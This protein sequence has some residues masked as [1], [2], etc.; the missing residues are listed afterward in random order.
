LSA[1]D[2][3]NESSA[4]KPVVFASAAAALFIGAY[5]LIPH[6]SPYGSTAIRLELAMYSLVHVVALAAAARVALRALSFERTFW[7]LLAAAAALVIV[8]DLPWTIAV[9]S[10]NPPPPT[11]TFTS[12]LLALVPAAVFY[13]LIVSMTQVRSHAWPVR[14]R[15][16]LSGAIALVIVF[17]A[18]FVLVTRPLM[19]SWGLTDTPVLLRGTLH[20]VIGIGIL[21]GVAAMLAGFKASAWK[22]WEKLLLAGFAVYGA[23]LAMTPYYY[24]HTSFTSAFAAQFHEAALMSGPA[25]VALAALSRLLAGGE[26]VPLRRTVPFGPARAWR[27][28]AVAWIALVAIAVFVVWA[29]GAESGSV[30]Q[31]LALASA[32]VL[33]GLLAAFLAAAAYEAAALITALT[34]DRVSGVHTID[35]LNEQLSGEVDVARRCGE[36]LAVLVIYVDGFHRYVGVHGTESAE[37]L[38]REVA[39]VISRTVGGAEKTA[40]IEDN[41]FACVVP[42][43]ARAQAEQLAEKVRVAVRSETPLTVSIG[44]AVF[45]EHG[46][47]AADLVD[48]A[49]AA[50]RWAKVHGKD[51]TEVFSEEHRRSGVGGQESG[52]LRAQSHLASLR[53]L[54]AAVDAREP[55]TRYHSQGVA[56]LTVLVARELGLEDERIRS[57]EQAALLHDIG[58]IAVAD[59]ILAKPGRL[60]PREIDQTRE[61][62]VLSA[63]ILA[64]S[65]IGEAAPWVR[66]HHERWDGTGYPDGL[67]AASIPLEAR[68][69]AV[70]D[71]YEAMTSHRS[72]RSRLSPAA[73]LQEIDLNMGL[74]FDPGVAEALIGVVRRSVDRA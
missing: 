40:R 13:V 55:D 48:S 37:R 52:A 72:Y 30:D 46:V 31:R 15:T 61:H 4:R 43:H 10:G 18:Y 69:I 74:Q 26:E 11:E 9:W 59:A 50:L 19:A 57:L 35:H 56:D 8:H 39:S 27:A 17:A 5:L 66:A 38:L 14:A 25:L 53:A 2:S 45:P 64:S 60:T 6:D 34:R 12:T 23:T 51:R 41:L 28:A 70:C 1:R 7:G 21:M 20:A 63:Q 44:L 42:G 22:P 62:P 54:A 65:V 47:E 3:H 24:V 58:K 33:I 16:A 73:A 67:A 36:P 71:A 49:A 32:V 68:I 29:V